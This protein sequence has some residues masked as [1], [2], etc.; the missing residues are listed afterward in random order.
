ME[1][2][3]TPT[4]WQVNP[5]RAVQIESVANPAFCVATMPFQNEHHLK[6]AEAN[7]AFVVKAANNH[8]A[9]LAVA[10]RIDEWET[11]YPTDRIFGHMEIVRIA[12][13]MSEIV[14]TAREIMRQMEEAKPCEPTHR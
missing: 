3:H 13:E 2:R 11:K 8:N 10:Q 4:P 1:V 7:A 5:Y 9:L 6:Q 14:K 12:E